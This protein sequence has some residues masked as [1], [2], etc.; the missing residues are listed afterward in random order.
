[1]TNVDEQ[2]NDKNHHFCFRFHFPLPESN[3]L[4]LPYSFLCTP[5][6]M[7]SVVRTFIQSS[8]ETARPEQTAFNLSV[9]LSK[10][11]PAM[12]L[13][14][15]LLPLYVSAPSAVNTSQQLSLHT[16]THNLFALLIP[17]WHSSIPVVPV[18]PFFPPWFV[19]VYSY[20]L[21]LRAL[22]LRFHAYYYK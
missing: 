19:S 21:P 14:F 6:M 2:H 22:C 7:P 16:H 1:M 18:S 15:L 4:T 8:E 11:H 17:S 10:C 13:Q 20:Q 9:G 3:E 12:V 5:E